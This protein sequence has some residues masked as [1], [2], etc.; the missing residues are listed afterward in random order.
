ML[1]AVE[2]RKR[3]VAVAVPSSLVSD[4]PH[5]REKTFRVGL[6]ARAAAIFR[7]DEVVIYPE[8]PQADLGEAEFL[9][10]ILLYL[11]TPQY[12]RKRMFPL[13]SEMRYVGVLPPLR[14]PHHPLEKKDQIKPTTYREGLVL[15]SD[16]D[17]ATV[18]IGRAKPVRVKGRV[19]LS[20]NR[21]TLKI[22]RTAEGE[23]FSVVSRD[24]VPTYWGYKVSL[25]ENCLGETIRRRHNELTII[26]SKYGRPILEELTNLRRKLRIAS[27]VIVV[28]GSP[29]EGVGEI[30]ARERLKPEDLSDLVLNTIPLQGTETVRTEEAVYATL[31]ILNVVGAEVEKEPQ[32]WL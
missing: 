21:V 11:E 8:S 22:E 27:R 24:D 5:L 18:D 3:R 7:V 31:A 6:L 15:C 32:S 4:T 16:R 25:S 12:L 10:K 30:L 14:T 20:G 23:R 26:T 17:S 1:T 29:R 28:F 19:L 2:K 9:R 13:S